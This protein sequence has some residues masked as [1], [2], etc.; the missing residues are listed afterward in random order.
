MEGP[1]DKAPLNGP[2]AGMARKPRPERF[3][4]PD[5][6]AIEADRWRHPAGWRSPTR[7]HAVSYLYFQFRGR[8]AWR[9]GTH[10]VES[11]PGDLVVVP[12]GVP[13][14]ARAVT[15][16][17]TL[18]L[19]LRQ[20]AFAPELPAELDAWRELTER[21]RL[22]E[23]G[24]IVQ[25]LAVGDARRQI[26]ALWRRAVAEWNR[27]GPGGPILMKAYGLAVLG[28]LQR[29]RTGESMLPPGTPSITPG[30]QKVL[31]HIEER[32][33]QA[34]PVTDLA[35]RAGMGR[36]LFHRRF[37]EITGATPVTYLTRLRLAEACR[38]LLETDDKVL[39]IGLA[40]GFNT[41]S[42]FYA[43][44]HRHIGLPPAVYRR[45]QRPEA[46]ASCSSSARGPMR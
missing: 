43:A 28:L 26:V 19:R 46:G 13:Y 8:M 22:A 25:P 16:V 37:R 27:R 4:T 17:E 9:V 3:A 42:R 32:P 40:C 14:R 10:E 15:M 18:L 44:F 7:Q 21:R 5:F 20:R 29:L 31:A 35:R 34:H 6:N 11:R 41:P 1:R 45:R 38:R 12:T 2:V 24:R 33:V 36:S 30:I 39:A 23:A